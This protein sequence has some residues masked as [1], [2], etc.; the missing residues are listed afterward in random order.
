MAISTKFL[1]ATLFLVSLLRLNSQIP[2]P[3]HS[4]VDL[5]KYIVTGTRV[6]NRTLAD[7]I[8]PID[9]IPVEDLSLSVSAE[10]SDIL[11]QQIPSFNVQRKP[12]ADGLIYVRPAT[13][14]GLSPDHTLV[15]INGKR[16]HRSPLLG[17]RGS[18]GVDL[19]QIPLNAIEHIEVLRD[20]ASAQYG[21]D[22][23]AGGINIILNTQTGFESFVQR[24]QYYAGDGVNWQT[25][26]RGGIDLNK[27]GYI[28]VTAFRADSE[29]TSRTRQRPD[30]I[31]FQEANPDLNV[32]NPV[33]RWGQPEREVFQL[34]FNSFYSLTDD[35]EVYGFGTYGKGD[36]MSDFN[37]RN[38]ESSVF[39]QSPAFPE[40]DLHDIYPTGFS[41]QFGQDD[42]DYQFFAGLRGGQGAWSW[43]ASVGKGG[44]EIAYKMSQTINA[45][46]GPESP[47]IFKPGKI[48]ED[49]ITINLDS[50][51][52][53]DTNISADPITIAFGTEYRE[54][55]YEEKA[56]DS[57]SYQIG[58]GAETG[59]PSGSN[60][61]PGFSP[62]QS[63]KWTQDST[64]FYVDIE[65][66]PLTNWNLE[67]AGRYE[68]FSEFGSNGDYKIATRVRLSSS[69]AW[70]S[71]ISSGF[72]APTPGQIYSTRTSQGLDTETLQ[73]YTAGRLSPL[74]PVSQLF[75]SQALKPETS[76]NISTGLVFNFGSKSILSIDFYQVMVYDRF[77]QSSNY[78]VTPEIKKMLINEGVAGAESFS[79]IN[80]FTNDFETQT[81][82][83]DLTLSHSIEVGEGTLDLTLAYNRN[84][85]EVKKGSLSA[86]PTSKAIFE[87]SLPKDAGNVSAK[88]SWSR[89]EIYGRLRYFGEWRD[90]SGQ[91]SGDFYQ[92]FG[93]MFLL[94][95]SVSCKF[96]NGISF[97][98]G[99]ENLFDTYPDEALLQANRGLIYSRNAPYD[100]DGGRWYCRFDY[101][102]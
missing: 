53:W 69:F 15:L 36:G 21:S 81:S 88:Y 63:G 17:N 101:R 92:D 56:G 22:A 66:S 80:F 75:G 14:R 18:Q 12:M 45:S 30:A 1:A 59:L 29:R 7:S 83:F 31:A 73:V 49:E 84:E 68:D 62:E 98:L 87:E 85:T 79:S 102:F 28:G 19:A 47:T 24:A 6:E 20:G 3:T 99:A 11:V 13:M 97:R 40:W 26:I 39:N 16:F 55:S 8:H 91:P 60:G 90:W 100:T 34:T 93:S 52:L 94:D 54:E 43:D 65:L 42:S 86:N 35:I 78:T 96:Q 71:A 33:Q 77:S 27:K 46:M 37:W 41:P 82:G 58:P 44:G 32:P 76:R 25:G 9:L 89:Y 5:E 48:I 38:P 57:A 64:A 95:L 4:I 51:Y 23:I 61:F 50:V 74:H 70:R 67:F 2:E 72:R 10:L